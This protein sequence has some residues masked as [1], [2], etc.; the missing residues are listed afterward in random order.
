MRK[1]LVVLAA[2]AFIVFMASGVYAAGTVSPTVAAKATVS[3]GCT[4]SSDGVIDFGF[5][6]SGDT[7]TVNATVTTAPTIYCTTGTSASVT[8]AS[9]NTTGTDFRLKGS[10]SDYINYT[11][12][13]TSTVMGKGYSTSI[14]G[15]GTGNLAMSASVS[16][17]YYN[18]VPAGAYTDTIT[19]TLSF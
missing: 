9:A 12:N 13:F 17:T 6:V 16:P 19:L 1:I 10:G 8:A 3:A 4:A 5:L 18:A 15:S 11:F 7:A 14:G 2:M